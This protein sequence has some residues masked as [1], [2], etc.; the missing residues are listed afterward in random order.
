MLHASQCAAAGFKWVLVAML[1]GVCVCV[2]VP[3]LSVCVF[4][5]V[6]ARVRVCVCRVCLSVCLHACV[7]GVCARVCVCVCVCVC[8]SVGVCVCEG[9][10][11]LGACRPLLVTVL[12]QQMFTDSE[13]NLQP[14]IA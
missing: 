7:L 3:C 13:D 2:S 9:E 12:C 14:G 11:L 10:L 4:A 8:L 5:W 1:D 6:C